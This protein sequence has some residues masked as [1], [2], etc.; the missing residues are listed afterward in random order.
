MQSEKQY[1]DLYGECRDMLRKHS[2]EVM[3]AVR[4]EAFENFQ[5]LGYTTKKGERYK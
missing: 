4:D 1:I 3:N 2:C 5:R